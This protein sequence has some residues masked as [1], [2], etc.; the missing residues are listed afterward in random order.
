MLIDEFLVLPSLF[1][2]NDANFGFQRLSP[3]CSS[4]STVFTQ[5]I[6]APTHKLLYQRSVGQH[7]DK[8][9]Y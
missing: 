9:R 4:S 3:G 5:R 7:P 6:G 1:K 2:D 8:N